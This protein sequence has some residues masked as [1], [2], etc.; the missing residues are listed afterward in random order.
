MKNKYIIRIFIENSRGV[1]KDILN[2]EITDGNLNPQYLV[3]MVKDLSIYDENCKI[4]F[5]MEEI[6]IDEEDEN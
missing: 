1:N 5:D 4:Y 2:K 3:G 6:V